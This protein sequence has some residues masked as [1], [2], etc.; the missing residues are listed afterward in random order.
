MSCRP[1]PIQCSIA[2]KLHSSN[3]IWVCMCDL[4]EQ[5]RTEKQGRAEE[6]ELYTLAQNWLVMLSQT[7][8]YC[9]GAVAL[10]MANRTLCDLQHECTGSAS[11]RPRLHCRLCIIR[12]VIKCM[13]HAALCFPQNSA[14]NLLPSVDSTFATSVESRFITSICTKPFKSLIELAYVLA[15]ACIA[16]TK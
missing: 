6:S 2:I 5:V 9:G 8:L 3:L 10:C 13:G 1:L 4:P 16:C 15:E 7:L 14:A 11:T 12:I